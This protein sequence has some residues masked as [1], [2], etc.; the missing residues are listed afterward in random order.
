MT[1]V[2]FN[3]TA[4]L[5][6]SRFH[7]SILAYCNLRVSRDLHIDLTPLFHWNTKQVFLYLEAEYTNA[8]GVSFIFATS[9]YFRAVFYPYIH[10]FWYFHSE[11][12]DRPFL[13]LGVKQSLII[14]HPGSK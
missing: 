14:S 8:K 7:P 12:I 3:I 5:I 13:S 4:G 9:G 10:V 6:D 11:Y 1:F 2:N